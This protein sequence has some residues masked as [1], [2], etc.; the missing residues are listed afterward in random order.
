MPILRTYGDVGV[1]GQGAHDAGYALGRSQRLQQQRQIDANFIADRLA[2]REELTR[3]RALEELERSR[4]NQ[5]AGGGGSRGPSRSDIQDIIEGYQRDEKDKNTIEAVAEQ[6]RASRE[7]KSAGLMAALDEAY[8]DKDK[9]LTYE[10]AKEQFASGKSVPQAVL[11][12]IGIVAPGK[13]DRDQ[14]ETGSVDGYAPKTNQERLFRRSLD[15]GNVSDIAPYLDQRESS[16]KYGA[17]SDSDPLTFDALAARTQLEAFVSTVSDR[18]L[19]KEY[20][21]DLKKSGVSDDA[22]RLIDERDADLAETEMKVKAPAAFEQIVSAF[23]PKLQAMQEKEGRS[24][25]MGEKRK[26]L[27]SIIGTTA[28]SYGLT[29]D[30]IGQ[31][32]RENDETRRMSEQLIQKAQD[33]IMENMQTQPSPAE[34]EYGGA[35][36]PPQSQMGRHR[37]PDRAVEQGG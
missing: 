12:Q 14:S 11:E 27:G 22:I 2:A 10:Y 30:Q 24:L 29:V 8:K 21:D 9:D 13:S 28:K 34:I 25:D 33:A 6:K 4:S 16:S 3:I 35:P 19:L 20:K 5:G 17:A 26:L 1:F 18:A 23:G 37:R 32:I 31:Y 7:A 15:Q 36:L